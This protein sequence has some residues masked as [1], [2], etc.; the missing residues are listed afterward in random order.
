[1]RCQNCNKFVS[2]G[3]IECEVESENVHGD[4]EVIDGRRIDNI[5]IEVTISLPCAECGEPLKQALLSFTET[6]EHECEDGELEIVSSEVEGFDRVETKDKKGNPIRNPRF[7][8]TFYGANL[9]V[10][11]RCTCGWTGSIATS[12]E[13]QASNFEEI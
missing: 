13:E 6:I 12:Q 1:M 5:D 3:D 10:E 11:L 4:P 2:Y 8:K 7:M 9:S